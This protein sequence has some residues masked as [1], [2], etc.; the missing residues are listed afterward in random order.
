MGTAAGTETE[1][2]VGSGIV[3]IKTADSLLHGLSAALFTKKPLATDLPGFFKSE[4]KTYEVFKHYF[5]KP[6][7]KSAIHSHVSGRRKIYSNW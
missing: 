2:I 6:L 5:H 7:E 1:E 3:N 4:M